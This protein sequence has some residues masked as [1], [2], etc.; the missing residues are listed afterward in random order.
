M[1]PD[2]EGS[3]STGRHLPRPFGEMSPQLVPE[4]Q[5]PIRQSSGDADLVP[6]SHMKAKEFCP[7][8]VVFMLYKRMMVCV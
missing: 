4:S 1:Q 3:G 5:E 8:L 2:K 7:E 6:E